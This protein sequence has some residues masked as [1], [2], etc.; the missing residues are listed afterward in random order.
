MDRSNRRGTRRGTTLVHSPPH[1]ADAKHAVLAVLLLEPGRLSL[2]HTKLSEPST[3]TVLETYAWPNA[4]Y[5]DLLQY[6]N[7][8]GGKKRSKIEL[9][10]GSPVP[11]DQLE[12]G[13]NPKYEF[14]HLRYLDLIGNR[15]GSA[16]ASKYELIYSDPPTK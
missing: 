3:N 13:V 16:F 9:F 4:T 14:M 6:E 11:V 5:F 12:D 1:D 10:R 15:S 2:A 7:T 8:A